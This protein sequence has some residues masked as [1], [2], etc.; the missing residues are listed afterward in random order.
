[1]TPTLDA[2]E[3]VKIEAMKIHAENLRKWMVENNISVAELADMLGMHINT[4]YT[5]ISG[6]VIMSESA[7][8]ALSSLTGFPASHFR[9]AFER[10]KVMRRPKKNTGVT[11]YSVNKKE[12]LIVQQL[13]RLNENLTRKFDRQEEINQ[14]FEERLKNLEITRH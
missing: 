4:I 14:S 2:S 8:V 11:V 5:W 10:K 1:M 6:T 7:S 13:V 12:D 3:I 9:T